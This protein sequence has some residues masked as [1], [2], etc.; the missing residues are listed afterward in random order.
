MKY[1]KSQIAQALED[2]LKKSG[3]EDSC[4]ARRDFLKEVME[5]LPDRRR[6]SREED[7]LLLS[8][9]KEGKKIRYI[10]RMLKRSEQSVKSRLRKLTL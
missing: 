10:A 9:K 1:T 7:R 6:W 5:L 4:N 8:L 2:Y 3:I